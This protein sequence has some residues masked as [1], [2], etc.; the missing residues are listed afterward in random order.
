[1]NFNDRHLGRI[2]ALSDR[3]LLKHFGRARLGSAF[4]FES[5]KAYCIRTLFQ[6]LHP[7]KSLT[8]IIWL[9]SAQAKNLPRLRS[10]TLQE[11]SASRLRKD[12]LNNTADHYLYCTSDITGRF[13]SLIC[14]IK[15]KFGSKVSCRACTRCNDRA[16]YS[17][18]TTYVTPIAASRPKDGTQH[19]GCHP[20]EPPAH[21]F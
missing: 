10:L 15:I 9:S 18:K 6:C 11:Q 7:G 4:G 1:M 20:R 16:Q 5:I 17:S 2:T 3:L 21:A 8:H 12:F 19:E 13:P 14:H